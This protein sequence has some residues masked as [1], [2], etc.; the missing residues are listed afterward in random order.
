MAA[1]V[2]KNRQSSATDGNP[3]RAWSS[4]IRSLGW[5]MKMVAGCVLPD[6]SPE[7]LCQISWRLFACGIIE[8]DLSAWNKK[9]TMRRENI[10]R[11]LSWRAYLSPCKYLSVF[12]ANIYP[13]IANIYLVFFKNRSRFLLLTTYLYIVYVIMY[14]SSIFLLAQAPS[15]SVAEHLSFLCKFIFFFWKMWTNF[16]I[17]VSLILVED[18]ISSNFF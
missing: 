17:S 14:L 1:F 10:C 8:D 13:F 4:S 7:R 12:P 15:Y 9:Q 11:G 16:K 18:I 6:P 3:S 2:K 5:I